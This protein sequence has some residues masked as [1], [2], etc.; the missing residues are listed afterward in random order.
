MYAYQMKRWF[1][2][3][4]P[5]KFVFI[6]NGQLRRHLQPTMDYLHDFVGLPDY[7]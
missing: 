1:K 2:V 6:T 4:E 3:Y 7:T 5:S